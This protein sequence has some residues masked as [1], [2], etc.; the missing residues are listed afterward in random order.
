LVAQALL[1]LAPGSAL[2]APREYT[3]DAAAS[4]LRV[5]VQ[6]QGAL[7]VLAHDHV[8]VAKGLAGRISFNADAPAA[9]TGEIS[10]PVAALEV[11]DPKARDREGFTGE[12]NESNRASV[13]A[14]MFAPDQLAAAAF[15]RITVS[16][17]RTEGSLPSL[18]LHLRVR[19]RQLEQTLTAPVTAT[20]NGD[21]L[22][23]RGETEL[24]QS[25]FGITPYASLLGAIAVQDAVRVK[26]ELVAR[27]SGS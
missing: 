14:N 1:L 19:I 15:P 9:S 13:R 11:D 26:F 22:M 12:L 20:L 5:V 10:I 23:V 2:A 27:A 17:E 3:L 4:L 25:A 16:V 8:L 6:R 7:S 21:T 18:R 24:L